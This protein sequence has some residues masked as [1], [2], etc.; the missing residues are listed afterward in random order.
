M[1]VVTAMLIFLLFVFAPIHVRAET[2]LYL[3]DLSARVQVAFG[4]IRVFN[5]TLVLQGKMLHCNGT[6]NADVDLNTLDRKSSMDLFKCIT[7]DKFFVTFNNNICNVPMLVFTLQNAI[8]SLV[9]A[10]L[11]NMYHCQFCAQCMPTITASQIK[12]RVLANFSV[13]ELSFCLL[14]QGVRKWIRK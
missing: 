12:L 6:I 1:T 8:I 14:K 2:T 4:H 11:C 3:S 5:E 7:V 10:T 13:A 9:T